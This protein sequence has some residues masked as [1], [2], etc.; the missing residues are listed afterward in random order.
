MKTPFSYHLHKH[1][2]FFLIVTTLILF[3]SAAVLLGDTRDSRAD[4]SDS[5]ELY[6][7]LIYSDPRQAPVPSL[8]ASIPLEGAKCSN[9]IAIN[10]HS[11]LVY[12]TNE[13]TDNVSILQDLKLV[14]SIDTGK[15]PINVE[16]DPRSD[17][18]YVSNIHSGIS[19]LNTGV[20]T[21]QIPAYYEPYSI[22]VNPVNNYTY[23]TDLNDPIT[24]IRG[25]E[26]IMD[27][28]VPDFNGQGIHWQLASGYDKLTGL[29]YF[30]SW[31]YGII[32]VVNG[33]EVVDQFQFYGEGAKD[34]AV[35]PYRR[36]LITTNIRAK[37]DKKSY[38]NISI[39]DLDSKQ[40]TQINSGE[41][42]EQV[43]I[44][45]LTGYAYVTNPADDTVTVLQGTNH[46]AT[47]RVRDK[48]R[49]VAVDSRTGFAYVTNTG[50][51][52]ITVFK[53]GAPVETISF[54]ENG[55]FQ[56]WQVEVDESNGRVY[57]LNRSSKNKHRDRVPTYVDCKKPWV[58][59]FQ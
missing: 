50:D 8:V 59:V 13:Q 54:E 43:D 5:M 1:H 4:N 57:V 10:H 23:V 17:T 25:S 58:H 49:S 34:L 27:L 37:Q 12:I 29:T 31:Q 33:T 16:S 6:F 36:L 52:S 9:D 15:W 53:N 56:P 47:Y 30:A 42:S 22:T 2:S 35:D 39:V 7:P 24:I 41:V 48:P 45:L 28:F 19:V 14:G 11:N 44:D 21:A 46:V 38:N 3:V 32:T 26:K 18:V 55:G 20:K 51:R 40:V